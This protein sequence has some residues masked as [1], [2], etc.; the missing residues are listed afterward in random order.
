VTAVKFQEQSP[1]LEER[2]E[3]KLGGTHSHSVESLKNLINLYKAWIKPEQAEQWRAKLPLEGN[4]Q[5]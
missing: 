1:V 2:P 4:T 5:K 3:D